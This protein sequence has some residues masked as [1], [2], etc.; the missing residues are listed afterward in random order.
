MLLVATSTKFTPQ[1]YASSKVRL[2]ISGC[3]SKTPMSIVFLA[4]QAQ[5]HD[6]FRLENLVFEWRHCFG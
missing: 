3:Y 6:V 5:Q 4:G 1:L 2:V